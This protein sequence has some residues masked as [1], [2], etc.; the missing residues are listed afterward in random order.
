METRP[1]TGPWEIS[2]TKSVDGEFLVV[3][4]DDDDFGLIAAVTLEEDAIAIAA[5]PMILDVL[6][7]CARAAVDGDWLANRIERLAALASGPAAEDTLKQFSTDAFQ[8]AVDRIRRFAAERPRLVLDEV[9][10][11]RAGSGN[12]P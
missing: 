2:P 9:A 8:E 11:A 4:G 10:R 12:A 6:E 1:T 5:L 3:G 7:E